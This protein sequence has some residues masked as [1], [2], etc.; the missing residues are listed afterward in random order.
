METGYLLTLRHKRAELNTQKEN[1]GT[2]LLL[3]VGEGYCTGG[4]YHS[5]ERSLT[6]PQA[7]L[8]KDEA[9]LLAWLD[10]YAGAEPSRVL[11][12]S[13]FPQALLLPFSVED[14]GMLQATYGLPEGPLF[15]AA[16]PEW[17]LHVQY[18]L[19][20][21]VVD[22]V[23]A[24]FPGVE[25]W[26]AY[27]PALRIFNGLSASEGIDLHFS[28]GQFRALVRRDGRLLLLQ[29]YAYTGPLDVVY[30]L[31]KI[32]YEFGLKQEDVPLLLSGSIMEDSALYRELYQYFLQIHWAR[33]TEKEEQ[34]GAPPH[35][36]AALH[37]LAACAS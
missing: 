36:Y 18:A 5:G 15:D 23:N 14:G 27:V 12:S 22:R 17:Q 7:G 2:W 31:L 20:G 21:S 1:H 33:A 37:N 26:H 24:S 32:C 8:W 10:R 3:E 16:V 29:T 35:L 28:S 34:A 11:L 6:D 4:L 19:P 30:I 25:Y 9:E 13:G